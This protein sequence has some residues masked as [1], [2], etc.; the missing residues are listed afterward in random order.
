MIRQGVLGWREE[1]K[2]IC[3]RAEAE[4]E[5]EFNDRQTILEDMI[6]ELRAL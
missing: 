4:L 1:I 6:L 5:N 2:R 3:D